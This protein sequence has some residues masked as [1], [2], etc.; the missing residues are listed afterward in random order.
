MF[1]VLYLSLGVLVTFA[2]LSALRERARDPRG[3]RLAAALTI[4][5]FCWPLA[6]ATLW[7]ERARL[8]WHDARPNPHARVTVTVRYPP[9]R[10]STWGSWV[11]LHDPRV[12][13]DAPLLP[14]PWGCSLATPLGRVHLL[15]PASA[16]PPPPHPHQGGFTLVELLVVI[17]LLGVLAAVLVPNLLLG[18]E[19][20][21][22]QIAAAYL[23]SCLATAEQRRSLIT[24]TV[25]LPASCEALGLPRPR[26]VS[27]ATIALSGNTYTIRVEGQAGGSTFSL[28][29]TLPRVVTP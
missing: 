23:Q 19:S 10:I 18:R 27:S 3:W 7:Y 13:F 22:R 1:S 26:H 20:A 4:G 29:D 6:L 8:A 12:V 9:R 24:T 5:M 14:H 25:T 28:Q 17:A 11:V 15:R 16:P 2:A 21:E